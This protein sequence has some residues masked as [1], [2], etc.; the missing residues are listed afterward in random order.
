MQKHH[1]KYNTTF[2]ILI[3]FDEHTSVEFAQH[4]IQLFK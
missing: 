3:N 1:R 4:L 2:W